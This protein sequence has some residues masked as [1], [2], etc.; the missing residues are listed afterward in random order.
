M[1]KFKNAKWKHLSIYI[2]KILKTN[3]K[4]SSFFFNSNNFP[5]ICSCI[6]RIIFP[7]FELK[8]TSACY[9][10]ELYNQLFSGYTTHHIRDE[11]IESKLHR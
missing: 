1:S 11:M 5:R 4:K 2:T 7:I 9:R 10:Q 3:V 6:R 8:V